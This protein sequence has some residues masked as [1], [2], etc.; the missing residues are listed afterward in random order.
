MTYN[1]RGRRC[2]HDYVAGEW[3]IVDDRKR[4]YI[5]RDGVVD[6]PFR[7]DEEAVFSSR[8]AAELVLVAAKIKGVIP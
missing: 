1:V 5:T 7:A 8:E 4:R 3:V 6:Q 2:G